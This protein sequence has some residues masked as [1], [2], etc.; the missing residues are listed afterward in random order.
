MAKKLNDS[1]I[2]ALGVPPLAALTKQPEVVVKNIV[3]RE[4]SKGETFFSAYANDVELQTSP[5]D[6]R[7]AFGQMSSHATPENPVLGVTLLGEV[8]ISMPLA[9]RLALI[10]IDQIN[11]Y[12]STVG[13]ISL[14]KD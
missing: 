10:M 8:R 4:V 2:A 1:G 11:A 6:M 12:E 3:K 9:K 14:P 7:F 5:W 13:P